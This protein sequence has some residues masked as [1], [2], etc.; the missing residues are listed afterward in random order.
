M[1]PLPFGAMPALDR[2]VD[3]VLLHGRLDLVRNI[4]DAHRQGIDPRD[5]AYVAGPPPLVAKAVPGVE[6]CGCRVTVAGV[7]RAA[8][9]AAFRGVGRPAVADDLGQEVAP[10]RL[11][12]LVVSAQSLSVALIVDPAPRARS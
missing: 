1:K 2:V 6:V 9:A 12:M 8:L 7:P 10:G 5:L 3:D 4:Q 11:V